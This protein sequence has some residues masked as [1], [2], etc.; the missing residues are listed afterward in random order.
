VPT[1]VVIGADDV[2]GSMEFVD[3][4][5]SGVPGATKVVIE[6]ADHVVNMRQPAEFDRV[7]LGFL[8]GTA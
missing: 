7:V 4:I 1:L 6:G 8:D 5:V 3:A 2:P